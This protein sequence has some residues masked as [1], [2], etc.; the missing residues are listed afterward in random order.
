MLFVLSHE[1]FRES[2]RS[3]HLI[4]ASCTTFTLVERLAT[5]SR[6][7]MSSTPPTG[8]AQQSTNR[9]DELLL[10]VSITAGSPPGQWRL[11]SFSA[12]G[13]YLLAEQ[14]DGHELSTGPVTLRWV[15]ARSQTVLNTPASITDASASGLR[16]KLSNSEPHLMA[17]LNDASND[18]PAAETVANAKS[19]PSFEAKSLGAEIAEAIRSH[20]DPRLNQLIDT[21]DESLAKRAKSASDS[22]SEGIYASEARAM[23]KQ[24]RQA[25]ISIFLDDLARPFDGNINQTEEPASRAPQLRLVDDNELHLWLIRS[26]SVSQLESEV[27][28]AMADL[29][30]R[31]KLMSEQSSDISANALEPEHVLNALIRSFKRVDLEYGLRDFIMRLCGHP[32]LLEL[33]TF[34]RRLLA[35]LGRMGL[36]PPAE[37]SVAQHVSPATTTGSS[38][39]ENPA[40]TAQPSEQPPNRATNRAPAAEPVDVASPQALAATQRLWSLTQTGTTAAANS[41]LPVVSDQQLLQAASSF[42][43][44]TSGLENADNFATT[45]REQAS[46]LTENGLRMEP[47]Q[48][49]AVE[50]LG[51]LDEALHL[52]PLLPNSFR[53]WSRK[54]FTPLLGTQLGGQD[55]GSHGDLIKRL[56]SLIEFGSIL[57]E[58]RKDAKTAAIR[59]QIDATIAQLAAKN[60]LSRADIEQA[61]HDLERLLQRQRNA[62]AAVEERV[63]EACQGQQKL[64]E[65][66][67]RVAKELGALF[68]G[69]AIPESL[70]HLLDESLQAAMVL[71]LLRGG[72]DG[73]HWRSDLGLLEDIDRALHDASR[74]LPNEDADRLTSRIQAKLS[75]IPSDLPRQQ[76]LLKDLGDSLAGSPLPTVIYRPEGDATRVMQVL[77][78]LN[79]PVSKA[80]I[81]QINLLRPG[82][83]V[84]FGT[85]REEPRLLKLAWRSAQRTRFVFVNQLGRKS[86]DLSRTQLTSLIREGRGRIL[87]EDN[88][89]IIER[90]WRRMLEGMHDELAQRATHDSLTGVLNRKEL[91]RRL[92]AWLHLRDRRPLGLLWVGV[93][94]LRL[95]N[96]SVGMEA[97]DQV[98]K[99]VAEALGDTLGKFDGAATRIAGDEF[100]LILENLEED[101]CLDLARDLVERI[102]GTEIE[103]E[104]RNL[105]CSVSIGV[106][107]PASDCID[108][109]Q[110]LIDAESA[111]NVAKEMGRGRAY[112]HQKDDQRLAQM[113]E[114]ATWVER[115]EAAL[116]EDD[117]ILYAQRAESLSDAAKAQPDYTEVLLRMRGNEGV[118][119]PEQFI[120]AAERYGQIAAVDRFVVQTLIQELA[121]ACD[122]RV[123]IGFNLSAR[124][125]VDE[126]FVGWLIN[127]LNGQS[128]P[129][130]QL[131][132][133]LTE[134]AAI[135]QLAEAQRGMSRLHQAGIRT[136][137]DDFGS[138]FSSYRY[139]KHLPVDVV[140]VDGAFIREISRSPEDLALAKSI[141][142][143]AHL[144]GKL[145]VAEHVE[146]KATLDLVRDIG[147]DYAQGFYIAN[148]VPLKSIIA[149][150]PARSKQ[151]A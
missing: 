67:H 137:L 95:L 76:K 90:A 29:N 23:L 78:T 88:S 65:A 144:L 112:L 35:T 106:A 117:L 58:E 127:E 68:G 51:R 60:Q 108:P 45:V 43:T 19:K 34:Y 8:P 126:E 5:D 150:L 42:S 96:Q 59:V 71:A 91:D 53:A 75:E 131:C 39:A 9:G 123:Q 6:T 103:H 66:R 125:I 132:V 86:E 72:A 146:D 113:R 62:G 145:T 64:D 37:A 133:E 3:G 11:E 70:A 41:D 61:C 27:R 151:P 105:H 4:G 24:H 124:N 38:T 7:F 111:C 134:T 63:V 129:L 148:P 21:A 20:F 77:Q 79:D 93:D 141:N 121:G 138:G 48:E 16:V 85:E 36:G 14:N 1:Q 99:S 142:E 49:E 110:M 100:V 120:L 31:L 22:L 17:L 136:V 94:R 89:S 54:L 87:D 81:E 102:G 140:K 119:T 57:C 25:L 122:R 147:F 143:I 80:M 73:A 74:G 130:A 97:G 47:R 149:T 101:T 114:T 116:R 82:D 2:R 69:R 15:N 30:S 44:A 10:T 12:G 98:L 26:E 13:M 55:L 118:H 56:F 104:G 109:A 83:W 18:Q 92:D 33:G 32:A 84:A 50:L 139:L 40:R 135:Q 128:F 115:V 46:R 107:L 28:G 52:D